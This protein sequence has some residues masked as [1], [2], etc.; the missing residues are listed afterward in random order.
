MKQALIRRFQPIIMHV[1]WG[2]EFSSADF[3]YIRRQNTEYIM[4]E[5]PNRGVTHWMQAETLSGP[6]MFSN[7]E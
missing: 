5:R 3:G 7:N 2:V 4:W 1:V 6:M